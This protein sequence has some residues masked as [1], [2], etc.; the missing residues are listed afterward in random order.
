MTLESLCHNSESRTQTTGEHCR[1]HQPEWSSGC[2]T[3]A[4]VTAAGVA[5]Q[6]QQ[7][8]GCFKALE[9]AVALLLVP[10]VLA[11]VWCYWV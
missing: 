6:T 9:V 4:L 3:S 7:L 11:I 1:L 8:K 10:A 2:A 5:A